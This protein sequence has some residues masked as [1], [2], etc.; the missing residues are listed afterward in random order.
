[1]ALA[2]LIAQMENYLEGPKPVDPFAPLYE[3]IDSASTPMDV[4]MA[5]DNFAK[6]NTLRINNLYKLGR[7]QAN[8]RY[9]ESIEE[10]RRKAKEVTRFYT[11]R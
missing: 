6:A 5:L 8:I 2:D 7:Y 9:T 3:A 4:Y 1:M 10:A 11:F